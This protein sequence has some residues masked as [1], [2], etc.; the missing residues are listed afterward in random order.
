MVWGGR[1]LARYLG[2]HL[3]TAEPYGESWEVSDH[4]LHESRLATASFHGATLRN[5]MDQRRRDLLGPAA[6]RFAVFPWLVKLLDASDWLSVQVHPD[7]DAVKKLLP[8][9]GGKTEAWYILDA[10]TDSRIYAGLK[11]GVGPAELRHALTDGSITECLHEFT[12][13]PGDFI[14]LPAGT[15]HAVG[16]GVFFA[17]IQQTSDATFRLFDWHRRDIKGEPR[18]LHLEEAFASIHW[19]QG[20]VE[21]IAVAGDRQRLVA[22][23]YFEVE[24]IR[25]AAELSL[26]GLGRLQA[27]IVTAGQGRFANGEFV[28]PG[29]VWILPAA[30]TSMLLH[31]EK[32]LAGLLC[33]LP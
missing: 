27:L 30:M 13:K 4:P 5:L 11:S 2:K 29:D 10:S 18:K 3:R 20:P 15:V 24:W 23:P 14:Y 16:G 21:P 31:L 22:C 25:A 9:E 1:N 7:E 26:G 28:M 33:T 32:P 19:D 8:G 6:E 17:E 12:P